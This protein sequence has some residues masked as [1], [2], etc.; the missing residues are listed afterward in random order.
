[1][2]VLILLA[3]KNRTCIF[4]YRDL[5]HLVDILNFTVCSKFRFVCHLH[6]SLH[7]R[8][9]LH[10]S[11][12]LCKMQLYK[13]SDDQQCNLDSWLDWKNPRSTRTYIFDRC[14]L[15]AYVPFK[16]KS[17]YK[18]VQS[19][20]FMLHNILGY[21]LVSRTCIFDRFFF[22]SLYF[23]KT[24]SVYKS[25]QSFTFMPH[26]I[27]GHVLVSSPGRTT[28]QRRP[29]GSITGDPCEKKHIT[30]RETVVQFIY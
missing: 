4:T 21:V 5:R 10:L 1:M 25:V 23:F 6:G 12:T 2:I 9:Q 30:S 11:W 17:V 15:W 14:F 22:L 7:N 16:T 24:K 8:C 27:L 26:N 19:F 29:R 13:N 3:D 18:Y 20:I 28:L